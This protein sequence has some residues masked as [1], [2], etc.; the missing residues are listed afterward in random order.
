MKFEPEQFSQVIEENYS[1]IMPDFF[2]METEYLASLNLIYHDLDASLVAM[3]LTSGLYKHLV[4]QASSKDK[5]SLKY[6]YQKNNYKLPINKFKINEISSRINLP[7][8]TVRRKKEKIIKDKLIMVNKTTK[9]YDFN[10]QMVDRKIIDSQIDNLSKFISKFS[11]FFSKN[12]FFVREISKDK[13]KQDI[14]E[15]FLLYLVKFLDFQIGYF[16]KL[17]SILDIESIFIILLCALNSS[18]QIVKKENPMRAKDL[19]HRIHSYNDTFGLNATSISEITQVPR[20]TVLRKINILEKK[21]LL[22]K[23]INKRYYVNDLTLAKDQKKISKIL[24]YNTDH[25]GKFFS[26]CIGIYK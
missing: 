2:E 1:H 7:R 21:G 15:K 10:A 14:E 25:L 13:I 6:F 22:K 20:T 18:A 19:F 16:S 8:E 24:T 12:K 3:V 11:I 4:E 5:I 9:M 26:E 17:K 23:D